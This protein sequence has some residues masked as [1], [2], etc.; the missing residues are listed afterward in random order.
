MSVC[1]AGMHRS[2]TSMVTKNLHACGLY[3]GREEDLMPPAAENPE[4]FWEHLGI[5]ALNDEVLNSLGGGWDCPPPAPSPA[6]WAGARLAPL[7]TR[8]ETIVAHFAGRERWGWKDPRS[9][10]TLPF[11]REILPE[12]KTIVVVRNPLEVALSLQRRN[13]A[14]FALG[15][16]LW[17]IYY[18]RLLDAAP[19]TARLVTHYDA[20][21]GDIEPEIRRLVAF[22]GLPREAERLADLR[23][24]AELR[25]HRLTAED[26]LRADVS[27]AV[28]SLYRDLCDEAGWRDTD[29]ARY[30]AEPRSAAAAGPSSLPSPADGTA[31]QPLSPLQAGVG[32]VDP[33]TIEVGVLGRELEI[34]RRALADREARIAVL[35]AAVEGHERDRALLETRIAAL[36]STEQ[37]AIASRDATIAELDGKLAERDGRVAER[38]ARLQHLERRR[39]LLEQE[40]APL[41]ETTAAQERSLE[42]TGRQVETLLRHEAELRLQLVAL[43]E[44]LLHKDAEVMATLGAALARHAPNAPAGAY[45]RQLLRQ[46]RDLVGRHLPPA[47]PLAVVG[48]GDDAMLQLGDRPA[49][50]FPSGSGD[51]AADFKPIETSAAIAQL[52]L[53][54]SQ[55]VRFLVVPSPGQSWLARHP[56]FQRYLAE[57]HPPVVDQPG[58]AAIYELSAVSDQPSAAEAAA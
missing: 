21:F 3:L 18:R 12:L 41:R 34:H 19:P 8:A 2:G 30:S 25:H 26:L 44:Q 10:L 6:E 39:Y 28:F 11:W 50:P 40:L 17:H 16:T 22:A 14:S 15:L 5:V 56:D 9:S 13:G 53:L 49:R 24:T 7:R 57:H 35:E 27:P 33:A 38:D 52:E 48:V 45:Y 36:A 54:R 51:V 29:A 58:V 4:G 1:I 42:A 43:H 31:G 23:T 20:F 47:A 32:H 55:G 37:E 46:V